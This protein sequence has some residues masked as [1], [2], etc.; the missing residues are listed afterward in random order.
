[1][2]AENFKRWLSI[3]VVSWLV[4]QVLDANLSEESLHDSEKMM[5]TDALIDNDAL[6][7]MELSQMRGIEGLISEDAIN[8][9]VLHGLELFLL[10]LL[11]KHLRANSRGMRSEDVLHGFLTRPARTVADGALKTFLVGASDALLVLLRHSL[12][13]NR[14]LTEESILQITG[15]MTL[16]LEKSIKVPERTLDPTVCWHLIEAH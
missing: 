7:L 9:E 13:S 12:A 10:G 2:E 16:R 4:L 3:G 14:V 15:W 1:M 11:E 6:D 8:G 5:K